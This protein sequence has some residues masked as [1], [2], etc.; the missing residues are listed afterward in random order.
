MSWI[1]FLCDCDRYQCTR[2]GQCCSGF[3][4]IVSGVVQG[5]VIGPLLLTLCINDVVDIFLNSA[6]HSRDCSVQIYADDLKIY[7]E[8]ITQFQRHIDVLVSWSHKWQLHISSKKILWC[9]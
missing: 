8:D 1:N 7:S 3:R 9:Y 2:V 6:T 4:K 5:S